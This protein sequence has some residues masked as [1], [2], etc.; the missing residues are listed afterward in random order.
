MAALCPKCNKSFVRD[1]GQLCEECLGI[2]D[3]AGLRCDLLTAFGG[4]G[5]R[6]LLQFL[7]TGN[8]LKI[9]ET[10][11]EVT[12]YNDRLRMIEQLVGSHEGMD[13]LLAKFV[14]NVIEIGQGKED[15]AEPV[16]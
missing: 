16:A 5:R 12:L 11:E 4:K 9:C 13:V 7:K 1:A 15:G 10:S 2:K 14:D 8:F 6:G 3:D